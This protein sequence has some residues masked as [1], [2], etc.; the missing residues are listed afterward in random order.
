MH[1]VQIAMEL[2]SMIFVL[3]LR[4]DRENLYWH[5]EVESLK[6]AYMLLV[7]QRR[8]ALPFSTAF[9]ERLTF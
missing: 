5:R 9:D 2:G 6:H 8:F 7:C 3:L 1:F 4:N